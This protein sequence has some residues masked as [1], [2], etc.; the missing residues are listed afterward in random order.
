MR[1]VTFFFAAGGFETFVSI[2]PKLTAIL[3]NPVENIV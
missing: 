3:A 2:K 1:C